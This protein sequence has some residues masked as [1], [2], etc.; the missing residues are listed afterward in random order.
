MLNLRIIFFFIGILITTLGIS[1]LVPFLFEVYNSANNIKTFISCSFFTLLV[2]ISILIAFRTEE[3]KVNIKDTIV[4]T[5]LSWPV[6]VLFS[7][8][9]FFYG[10]EVKDFSEVGVKAL[11]LESSPV[12]C[13]GLVVLLGVVGI[14]GSKSFTLLNV[15]EI[16]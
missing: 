7:S 4:I 11:L 1:M 9:P 8:L 5:T 15:T 13:V 2:G 16:L 3:K 6:L 12:C 10:T 14:P